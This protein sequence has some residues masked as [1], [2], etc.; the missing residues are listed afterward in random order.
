MTHPFAGSALVQQLEAEAPVDAVSAVVDELGKAAEVELGALRDILV[1]NQRVLS[2]QEMLVV[3]SRVRI[4]PG[5]HAASVH[6][7]RF[8]ARRE[9][10]R[11]LPGSGFDGETALPP[12]ADV[13]FDGV[14]ESIF[15]YGQDQF[16][17]LIN[18][19]RALA[20]HLRNVSDGVVLIDSP[21]GNSLP[22]AVLA[23]CLEPA[24]PTQ[25][26][27]LNAP[28]NERRTRGLAYQDQVEQLVAQ[29]DPSGHPLI[30]LDDVGTGTRFRK[31]S[32][33]F[34]K[35]TSKIGLSFLQV[36]MVFEPQAYVLSGEQ[37][38]ARDALRRR[39]TE[40]GGIAPGTAWRVFPPPAHFK[41][42]S[43][44]PF[45]YE[46][47]PVWGEDGLLAG[48]RKLNFAFEIL[49]VFRRVIDDLVAPASEYRGILLAAWSKGIDGRVYSLDEAEL[50]RGLA[51][52]AADID[53]RGIEEQIRQEF[54]ADYTGDLDGIT[55]SGAQVR[56]A[57]I[58]QVLADIAKNEHEPLRAQLLIN[59]AKTVTST[60]RAEQFGPPERDQAYCFCYAPYDEPYARV[61][62]RLIELTLES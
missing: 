49:D 55:W 45:C 33:A 44:A 6:L 15:S 28:R 21:I 60:F 32:R 46:A 4:L 54:A 26:A 14:A 51:E 48:Q 7:R 20:A 22:I 59:A 8:L 1:A 10:V 56:L 31:L 23:S 39:L 43:G 53:W 35:A 9:L 18:L 40:A 36:A 2:L 12:E 17:E 57:R 37:K 62:R 41:I 13:L 50:R 52:V 24:V 29:L 5:D 47:S 42:D 19:C 11:R 27:R 25:I 61:H 58:V 3:L 38:R 16:Q 34:E 30:Y